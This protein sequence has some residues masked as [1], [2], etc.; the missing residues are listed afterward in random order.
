VPPTDTTRYTRGEIWWYE[1]RDD[2]AIM[3]SK[4]RIC[5]LNAVNE[6]RFTS[7]LGC[8]IQR[9]KLRTRRLITSVV[10]SVTK[11]TVDN[12]ISLRDAL[13]GPGGTQH[14]SIIKA[15]PHEATNCCRKR[16]QIV[17]RNGN[18]LLP[19]LATICCRFR[20]Q[21]CLVWTGHK[22]CPHQATNCVPKTATNCC[23]KLPIL[24]TICCRFRQQ[25]CLVWTGH[26]IKIR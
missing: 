5:Q 13:A 3:S 18:N 4:I 19:F 23:R 22:A 10:K 11:R 9:N 1:N 12:Y 25:S 26:N 7:R 2:I 8:F 24:A 17:A 16:Q 21:S 14:V 20:Q 15:C 6:T